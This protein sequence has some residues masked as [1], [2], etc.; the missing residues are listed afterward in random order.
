LVKGAVR[1]YVLNIGTKT[2]MKEN[3]Y[4]FLTKI[5]A[6]KDIKDFWK[7]NKIKI[8]MWYKNQQKP[9]DLVISASP[10]FLLK[11]I[12][13]YLGIKHLIASRV[14]VKTGK[15]TGENCHGDEKV[16]M[17]K[18]QFGDKID[19]F[20]SDSYNDEP[21]ARMSEKAFMVKGS[22]ITEWIFKNK[23]VKR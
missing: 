19:E 20:Y 13:E 15:Y 3:M 21:L 7:Q 18:E 14:D 8:K 4:R 5:D 11:P 6:E 9:D 1:Y 10:Y 16:K 2:I 17:F 22:E 23:Q 12:C